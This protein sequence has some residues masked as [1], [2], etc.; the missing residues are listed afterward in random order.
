MLDEHPAPALIATIGCH[1][2]VIVPGIDSLKK[3]HAMPTFLSRA[4]YGEA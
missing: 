4:S 2:P 3:I 1:Q